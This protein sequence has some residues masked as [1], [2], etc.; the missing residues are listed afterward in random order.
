MSERKREMENQNAISTVDNSINIVIVSSYEFYLH[1]SWPLHRN[2]LFPMSYQ[3]QCCWFSIVL[4]K[5]CSQKA[6]LDS[7]TSINREICKKID[8]VNKLLAHVLL[9]ATLM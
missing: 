9:V 4:S 7:K 1:A 5:R 2:I 6:G 8:C 3:I